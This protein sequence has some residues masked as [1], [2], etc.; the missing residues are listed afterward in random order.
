MVKKNISGQCVKE[1]FKNN[2]KEQF[3]ELMINDEI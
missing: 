2:L 1:M 3:L